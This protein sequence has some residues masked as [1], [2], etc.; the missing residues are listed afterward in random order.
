MKLKEILWALDIPGKTIVGKIAT[1]LFFFIALINL[2]IYLKHLR[3]KP[4]MCQEQMHNREGNQE[5]KEKKGNNYQ[6]FLA[7]GSYNKL[8]LSLILLQW[9]EHRRDYNGL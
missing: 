5:L 4:C 7:K 6:K 2:K 1:V 8:L 9:V 3:G